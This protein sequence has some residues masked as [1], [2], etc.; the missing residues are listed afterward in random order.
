MRGIQERQNGLKN[1]E[2]DSER[3]NGLENYE[4]NPRKMKWIREL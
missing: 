3:R 2:R 4:R 1:Y